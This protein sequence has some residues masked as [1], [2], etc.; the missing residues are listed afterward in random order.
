MELQVL[1]Y[2]ADRETAVC[3][4]CCNQ[5]GSLNQSCEVLL[6]NKSVPIKACK[7]IRAPLQRRGAVMKCK[8]CVWL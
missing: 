8:C 2:T 7:S 1:V 4:G 3:S 6:D 5:R